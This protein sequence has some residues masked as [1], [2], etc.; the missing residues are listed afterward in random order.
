MAQTGVNTEYAIS[1]TKISSGKTKNAR[2][3]Q[4]SAES[5]KAALNEDTSIKLAI[6]CGSVFHSLRVFFNEGGKKYV[7]VVVRNV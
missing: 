3:I 5:I 4:K 1:G 7:S 6:A 2:E